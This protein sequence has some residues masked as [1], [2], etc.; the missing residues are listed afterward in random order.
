[1]TDFLLAEQEDPS[2]L[3]PQTPVFAHV[4]VNIEVHTFE[5]HVAFDELDVFVSHGIDEEWAVDD[6]ADSSDDFPLVRSIWDVA[7]LDFHLAMVGKER[8]RSEKCGR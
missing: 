8:E 3:V 4:Q 5:W 2:R 6:G 7:D 1:M